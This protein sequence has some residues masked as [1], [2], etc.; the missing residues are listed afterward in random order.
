MSI[1]IKELTKSYG[2]QKAID[3]LSF[4]VN[5]GEIV[6]FLGPNGAGKSTTMKVCTG[7]IKPT[8]GT[9]H[10]CGIDVL[11][12][13]KACQQKIGYLPEHNPLYLDDY[14]KEYL[15]FSAKA[16]QM[17]ASAIKKR[18]PELIDQFGDSFFD[19]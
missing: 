3:T 7:Y 19:S 12:N 4:S 9:A 2:T 5:K 14:V 18:I 15:A 17:S 10:I 11:Q 16:H 8:S 1:E 6:G 13:P